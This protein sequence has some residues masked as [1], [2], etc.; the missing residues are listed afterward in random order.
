VASEPGLS[1]D[2]NVNQDWQLYY[3]TDQNHYTNR[4]LKAICEHIKK[5]RV[6]H[7]QTSRKEAFVSGLSMAFIARTRNG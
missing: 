4:G 2:I 3:L 6:I 1:L 5:V 7:N